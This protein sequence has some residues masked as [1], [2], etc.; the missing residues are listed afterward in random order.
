MSLRILA[1]MGVVEALIRDTA[2]YN[3]VQSSFADAICAGL[4]R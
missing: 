3:P 2:G 4:R 1:E